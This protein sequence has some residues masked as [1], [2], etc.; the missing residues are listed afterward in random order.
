MDEQD[1]YSTSSIWYIK[2]CLMYRYFISAV[3]LSKIG[4]SITVICAKLRKT[5]VGNSV[6]LYILEAVEQTSRDT[7]DK[8]DAINRLIN[9]V[10]TTARDKT[11]AVEPRRICRFALQVALLQD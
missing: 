1:A 9:N 6:I 4:M 10:I 5:E 11:K 8:I 7:A 2:D 3:S